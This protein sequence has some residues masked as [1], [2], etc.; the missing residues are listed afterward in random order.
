M[1][2]N[3]PDK[4][5]SAL[6]Y[7]DFDAFHAFMKDFKTD[8][9]IFKKYADILSLKIIE[10]KNF[11][12]SFNFYICVPPSDSGRINY[13][14]KLAELISAKTGKP[15]RDGLLKK[16]KITKELKSLPRDLRKTEIKDSFTAFL[17]GGERICVID[18]VSASGA[19]ICEISKTLKNSGA[20]YV[21]AAVVCALSFP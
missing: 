3:N 19:T 6:S 13:S 4:I 5:I 17:S 11:F 8:L 10:D 16:I 14:L 18:D 2:I 15:L 20:A 9:R 21:C 1:A 7:D 12:D